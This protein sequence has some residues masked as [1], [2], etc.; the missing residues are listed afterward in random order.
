MLCVSR[1]GGEVQG[2]SP[3]NGS[4]PHACSLSHCGVVKLEIANVIAAVDRVTAAQEPP[5]G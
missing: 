5:P 2:I 4:R 1:Y 3:I